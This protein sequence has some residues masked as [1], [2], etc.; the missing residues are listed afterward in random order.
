MS[1]AVNLPTSR[2]VIAVVGPTGVGKSSLADA[3][4]AAHRGE[5]V[6][7]DS[8]QVYR[9]MDVGTAKVP[10][11]ERLVPYHCIDL[12]EPGEE[13]SAALY[14]RAAREAIDDIL[15]RDLLPVVVG[16][17]GLYVRAALDVLEF[18]SGE[19]VTPL[20]AQLEADAERL[21]GPAMYERLRELDPDAAALIHVNNV[22]RMIRAIEMVHAG[23]SY[24]TQADGFSSRDP[25]YATCFIGLALPRLALY[26]RIGARVDEMLSA[27]LLE[28]IEGLLDAGLRGAITASQAIGYKE[29][30]P[31][32]EGRTPLEDA[33]ETV[34]Q[35]TRR[36]AKRQLTWFKADERVRWIDVTEMSP[37]RVLERAWQLVESDEPAPYPFGAGE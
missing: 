7:A 8:M 17:T 33:I 4:A 3:L 13:Y 29:F 16:G 18:P 15:A 5:I 19:L 37:E 34:K 30:V 31:V 22:R 20:R 25:H 1:D 24:A 12:V 35:A 14:Q 23:T 26:E 6:S 10:V 11:A 27:G 32:I 2:Q 28:E 21:G 36:Y 9:G